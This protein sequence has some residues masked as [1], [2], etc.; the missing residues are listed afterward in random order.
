MTVPIESI[1]PILECTPEVDPS[2]KMQP[3]FYK[4]VGSKAMTLAK[5]AVVSLDKAKDELIRTMP[6]YMTICDAL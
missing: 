3:G 4:N 5:C 6:K 1:Y 2:D